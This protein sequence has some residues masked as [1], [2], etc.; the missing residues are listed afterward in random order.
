M[1]FLQKIEPY[2]LSED[3][4]IQ[5]FVLQ[6]LEDYPH[7]P[8][9]WTERLV[10]EAMRCKGTEKEREILR[11]LSNHT[12]SDRA[13][14][15]LMEM[16]KYDNFLYTLDPEIA[17]RHKSELLRYLSKE[18]WRMYELMLHGTKEEIWNEYHSLVM[19]LEQKTSYNNALF[20][21]AKQMVRALV[22]NGWMTESYIEDVLQQNQHQ[23]YFSYEGIFAVY[24]IGLMKIDAYIPLVYR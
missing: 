16:K 11:H 15:L 6:A 3:I 23:D 5:S 4:V 10:E 2:L 17:V 20:T 21:A 13:V 7:V 14:Q 19:H 22:Q 9:E 12:F 18:Q 24:A 8:V 1:T